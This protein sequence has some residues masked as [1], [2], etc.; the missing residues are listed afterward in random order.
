MSIAAMDDTELLGRLEKGAAQGVG[1]GGGATV[2]EV[3]GVPVFAKRIP[4]SDW[5][6]AHPESTVNLFDLPLHCNY[7]IGSPSLSAWRELA[8]NR[9]VTDAVLIGDTQAFPVLYHWRVLPGRP[10]VPDEYADPE[11]VVRRFGGS[12][13]V[14][15][16][17]AAMADASWSLVL[18]QEYL[19]YDLTDWLREDPVGR[20]P[21]LEQGLLEIVAL[22][23]DRELLHMDGHFGNM[24]SDGQRVYLVDFGLVTSPRFELSEVERD[25]VARNVTHDAGYAAMRLVNWLATTVCGI[26]MPETGG[27]VERNEFVKRCAAGDIPEGLPHGISAMLARH[28]P[29][30]AR[31][32]EFYWRLFGGDLTAQYESG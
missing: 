14:R 23:R 4:L 10:P 8:A 31:L 29:D 1:V 5:E 3:D 11:Q 21:A 9:V 6:M 20:A 22:L 15:E 28:A 19:P 27:P 7:G 17:L 30:A 2:I 13:R 24:R 32:N 12:P 16:R 18:F 26:P 25:F